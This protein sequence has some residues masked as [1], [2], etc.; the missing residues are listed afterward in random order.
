[1]GHLIASFHV[2]SW[3]V[4]A[5]QLQVLPC[6]GEIGP[7]ALFVGLK[8]TDKARTVPVPMP[9]PTGIVNQAEVLIW[10]AQLARQGFSIEFID[11]CP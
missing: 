3:Y 10:L 2:P 11:R 4:S 1:M 8:W 7:E 6:R 9:A 5:S